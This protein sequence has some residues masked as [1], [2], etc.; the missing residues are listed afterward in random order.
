MTDPEIDYLA[1]FPD[2]RDGVPIDDSAEPLYADTDHRGPAE[3]ITV[4][5]RANEDSR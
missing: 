4:L 1:A 5:D 2:L 3:P